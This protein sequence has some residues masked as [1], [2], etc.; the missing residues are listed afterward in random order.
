[1]ELTAL[2]DAGVALGLATGAPAVAYL[3]GVTKGLWPLPERTLPAVATVYAIAWVVALQAAG[4]I[5]DHPVA[6]VL[7][8][9]VLGQAAS[10]A[11]GW[12]RTYRERPQSP[13]IEGRR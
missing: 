9:I 11:Q 5:D 6:L 4:R 3:V 7:H 1:M 8:G 2:D 10:G 13:P 12:Y